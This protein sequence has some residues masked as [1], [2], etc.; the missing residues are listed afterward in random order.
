MRRGARK[1]FARP[2]F[3]SLAIGAVALDRIEVNSPA[4]GLLYVANGGSGFTFEATYSSRIMSE[5]RRPRMQTFS[6]S[7]S[8]NLWRSRVRN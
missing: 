5:R 7:L 3:V 6:I 8:S 4:D 1:T 2:S